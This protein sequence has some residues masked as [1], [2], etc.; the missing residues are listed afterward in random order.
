MRIQIKLNSSYGYQAF[1][2]CM[3]GMYRLDAINDLTEIELSSQSFTHYCAA[4]PR[5]LPA[6]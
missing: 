1:A 4:S 3:V 5:T 6:S 2:R